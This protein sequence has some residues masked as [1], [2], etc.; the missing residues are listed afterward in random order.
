[1]HPDGKDPTVLPGEYVTDGKQDK[2][3]LTEFPEVSSMCWKDAC[4]LRKMSLL[5]S[6][7]LSCLPKKV[8]LWKKAMFS[9]VLF[10]AFFGES[11]LFFGGVRS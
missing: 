2:A 8:L 4:N 3:S 5:L 6:E 10:F 9:V 11:F 7:L 1:M